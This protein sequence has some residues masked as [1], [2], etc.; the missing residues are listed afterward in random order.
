MIS[1]IVFAAVCFVACGRPAA[2]AEDPAV[3][4]R[5]T[6][7]LPQPQFTGQPGEWDAKIRERGWILR[8]GSQ[9]RMWYTGY[10]PEK[11][12]LTMKLGLATSSD[13]IHWKRSSQ[14]PLVDEYW[15]EDMMV[16]RHDGRYYM[17]AEG[18]QD[19]AQLFTSPDGLTWTREG[20]LDVRLTNGQP[21]PAGPFGTPSAFIENGVWHLLYER[22]DLGVWLAR[23]PDLKVWTNVRDEP[24]LVP[25][26]SA[27]DRQMLAL[28]QVQK[29]GDRY[30][31]VLHGTGD[32]QKP[33]RWSTYL[34][35][36]RDLLTWKK[37]ETPI[38]EPGENKSS[39]L[40][41][42]DGS[43]WRLYT[44]HDRVDLHWPLEQQPGAGQR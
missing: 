26:P 3:P 4:E 38:T 2:M 15:V 36:S 28:N 9:W 7:A 11:Q 24:V 14:N 37:S 18:A 27:F 6:A 17:F 39:G 25:G 12:P 19:Q 21:I 10:D 31:A 8:E 30:V 40:L 43:R 1:R 44:T 13:G 34:A 35:E 42:H 20:A 33:R 32:E 22:R 41:L 29:L 23:S 16:V 5:F